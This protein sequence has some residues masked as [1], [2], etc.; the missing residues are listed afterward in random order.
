MIFLRKR[1]SIFSLSL[2]L[3][4]S[5]FTGVGKASKGTIVFG[6]AGWESNKFHNA[7]AGTIAEKVFDYNWEETPGSS[8]VVHEG[9]LMGEIDVQMEEWTDNL[10]MYLQDVE[11][12]KLQELSVNFDDNYQGVYVPRYVIEGDEERGIEASAP[13]LEYIWDLKKY[14][15]VFQDAE[16][17]NKGRMYGAITGWKVD[18]ILRNKFR[19]YGLDENFVY[20]SPGSDTALQTAVI[21]AYDK[22]EAV[23]SYYW[24]PTALLGKYDMVLLKD[25]PYVDEEAFLAGETELPSMRVTIAASNNFY[26]AEE[27]QEFVEFLSNYETSSALTSKALAYM[28][29]EEASY[30]EAALW[31]LLNHKEIV[32]EWLTEEEYETLYENLEEEVGKTGFSLYEFPFELPVDFNKIDDAVRDF[33]VRHDGFFSAITRGLTNFVNAIEKVLHFIPWFVLIGLVFFATYQLLGKMT[34]AILYS[35]LLFFIGLVGYWDLMNETLAIIL[36]S[37]A[38]SLLI[39][40]P[41][42]ILIS[43]SDKADQIFRPILDTM[44]TM[45][46]FVY[47]IP[48]LLFFGLGK[49]PG[50]I[51]TTIYAVVPMIRLTSLGI[52]SIDEE[53]VEASIAFGSTWLQSLIKVQIPQALPTIMTGINQTIMMAISM[54]V[55]TS[56][57][58]VRG[59]GMEVLDGVNKIEIGRGLISGISVVIIAIILDRITQGFVAKSEVESDGE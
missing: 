13:D 3:F 12:G 4:L 9:L 40:F 53:V 38:I 34:S 39:G 7:V 20:F 44:Q 47:L 42:G 43:A 2:L 1:I 24:E 10:P 50:V 49:A 21:N 54:V 46:V 48:A 52:R 55:T 15:E 27:N 6:D 19:N 36:A 57:I 37:V 30:K 58:G 5:S 41:L 33:S 17:P 18:T 11:D 56:M 29:D 16:N 51:A 22:G 59:L 14:P 25:E 32:S 23:A 26:E 28:E 35:V 8:A 31:F 45:P